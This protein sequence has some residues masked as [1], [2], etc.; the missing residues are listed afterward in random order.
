MRL[1]LASGRGLLGGF[2]IALTIPLLG[3]PHSIAAWSA[4]GLGAGTRVALALA[5]LLGAALFAFE[6]AVVWGG[7]LLIAAF[8]AAAL[9]HMRQGELPWWLAAFA[10]VAAALLYL[11]LRARGRLARA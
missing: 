10:L 6:F 11:T 2:L 7:A 3:D 4:M 5:E 9:L 1:A 8:A